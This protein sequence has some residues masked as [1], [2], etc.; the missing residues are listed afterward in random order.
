MPLSPKKNTLIV[1]FDR[2]TDAMAMEAAC[3]RDGVPGRIIPMPPQI[4]AGCGM[5]WKA[6]PADRQ[7][8]L[9]EMEKVGL[10][11]SSLHE[12]ML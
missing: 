7:Q 2:T 11:P 3:E 6:D 5:V 10:T 8:I 12:L 4:S 1:A 9:D